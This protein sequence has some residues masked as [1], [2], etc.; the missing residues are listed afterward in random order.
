[1]TDG[2]HDV[3]LTALIIDGVAHGFSINGQA[4]ILLTIGLVPALQCKVEMHGIYADQ[5]ITDD[6]HAR[7]GVALVLV[8]AEKTFPGLFHRAI[9]R[10][11]WG[12]PADRWICLASFI[13]VS[14][15]SL[16]PERK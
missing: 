9:R 12:Q 10:N 8:S 1:M 6:G 2:T 4:F 13:A 11:F 16:P 15:A 3:G 5:Y 7:Y 14:T